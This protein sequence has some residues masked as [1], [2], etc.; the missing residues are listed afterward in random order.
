LGSDIMKRRWN[1]SG[2]ADLSGVVPFVLQSG[3]SA[4][5]W[6]QT[7]STGIRMF[8]DPRQEVSGLKRVKITGGPSQLRDEQTLSPVLFDLEDPW[9]R[10]D[11]AETR[12]FPTAGS[13]REQTNTKKES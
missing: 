4:R 5:Y 9:G 7:Y 8:R 2:M 3:A 10:S 6:R 11:F 1:E 13:R 12:V